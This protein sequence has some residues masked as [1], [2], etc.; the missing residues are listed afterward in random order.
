MIFL[1]LVLLFLFHCFGFFVSLFPG[2][3]M[4][5]FIDFVFVVA[6]GGRE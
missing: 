5:V 4:Y 2:L 3:F 1:V 6:A